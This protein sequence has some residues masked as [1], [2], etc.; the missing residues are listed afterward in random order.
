MELVRG[1][2]I[3]RYCDE[4]RLALRERLAIFQQGCAALQHAHERGIVHRDVKPSNLLVTEV[5][6]APVLKVIDFGLAKAMNQR[7]TERTLFTEEGRIIGTPEYMSPEQAATSAQDV[8]ARSD[9]FS[10]G[11]VLYELLAGALPFD[12]QAARAK[13]YFEVQRFIR[14]EEPPTPLRRISGLRNSLDEIL[15]LR[16]CHVEGNPR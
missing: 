14:E 13:G 11:V 8:D 7:L 6:G 10:L 3:T 15:A 2:P 9:V 4:N 5:D 16:R 12:F 1:V